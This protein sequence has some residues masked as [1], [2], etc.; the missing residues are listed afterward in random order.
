MK[1][2]EC[3]KTSAPRWDHPVTWEGQWSPDASESGLFFFFFHSDIFLLWNVYM[4]AVKL[5]FRDTE[6][7]LDI[8][9]CFCSEA[10]SCLTLQ[11]GLQ[12]A[13]LLC[14]PLSPEVCS[15]SCP[16]N[17][18]C[19]PTD[20]TPSLFAFTL[21]VRVCSSESALCIRWPNSIGASASAA[22]LLMNIQGW[23]PFGLTVLTAL[24]SKESPAPQFKSIN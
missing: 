1:I 14:P 16:L 23:F 2:R 19:S 22:V 13:R 15:H 17:Q 20:S 9:C 24:Q 10:K 5:N 7:H 4:S 18:W 6:C 3:C 8:I 11:H 12:R 21:W